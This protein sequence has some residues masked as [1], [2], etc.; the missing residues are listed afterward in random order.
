MFYQLS[1]ED[2]L[3]EFQWVSQGTRRQIPCKTIRVL[4]QESGGGGEGFE[5]G[6]FF[7]E[8]GLLM[9]ELTHLKLDTTVYT[10]GYAHNDTA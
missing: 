10:K 4:I 8:S 2:P 1:Y 5:G 6:R 9:Q 7:M 3:K